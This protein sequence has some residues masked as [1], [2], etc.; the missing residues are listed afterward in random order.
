MAAI[1]RRSWSGFE[2]EVIKRLGNIDASGFSTRVDNWIWQAYQ[3]LALTYH[4]F[5]LDE[6]DKKQKVPTDDIFLPL[7]DDCYILI[8]VARRDLNGGSMGAGLTP[9]D[10][11]SILREFRNQR[12]APTRYGRY[13]N[14]L[15]LNAIGDQSYP[16]DIYY[17]RRPVEPDFS[18][19]NMYPEFGVDLD[20][21]LINLTLQLAF[22]AVGRPDLGD[23]AAQVASAYLAMQPR[24][25]LLTEPLSNRDRMGAMK[26]LGGSQA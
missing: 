24:P 5:E 4:H 7:P 22:P 2:S 26:T 11:G 25:P 9:Y 10:P 8:A 16:L 17:Y 23:A 12:T 19:T 13:N 6:V 14:K 15:V 21:T 1:T 3:W 20:E 18:A